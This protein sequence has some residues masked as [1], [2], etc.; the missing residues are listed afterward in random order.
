LIFRD[1]PICPLSCSDKDGT[2]YAFFDL[3]LVNFTWNGK[4]GC[5]AG[6]SV[7][8]MDGMRW[9]VEIT[10]APAKPSDPGKTPEPST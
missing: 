9:G 3:F 5:A 1:Q 4:V 2:A 8:I 10:K 7:S 6:G